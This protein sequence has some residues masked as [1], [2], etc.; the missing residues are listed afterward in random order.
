[1]GH[2]AIVAVSRDPLL[3]VPLALSYTP[4]R[5]L[6]IY[7][8]S[9]LEG[10][11]AALAGLNDSG[12]ASAKALRR[13]RHRSRTNLRPRVSLLA[14]N[15]LRYNVIVYKT[16]NYSYDCSCSVIVC[17]PCWVSLYNILCM[18]GGHSPP[19]TVFCV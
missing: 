8:V 4:T 9:P 1:M 11:A 19:R 16:H 6:K 17:T 18:N 3:A 12:W 10:C 14:A 13:R 5:V 2:R 15:S 7:I